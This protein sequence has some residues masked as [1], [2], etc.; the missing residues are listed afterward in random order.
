[1]AAEKP[2]DDTSVTLMMRIRQE[3]ADARAWEEFVTRYQPMI[4][5]W[6]RN[7]GSR[8]DDA[9]DVAQEVLLKLLAAMKTFRYDPG[10]SFG[11]GSRR[12]P[13]MPGTITS[14][15]TVANRR[16]IRNGSTP[17]STSR[18]RR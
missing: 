4:R 12:S 8:P 16:R 11:P 3:P 15:R 18:G 13:R 5:D 10:R 6:C 17:S 1:M 9:E 7:W 14:S 2:I